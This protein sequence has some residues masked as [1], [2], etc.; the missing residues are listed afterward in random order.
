MSVRSCQEPVR[1]ARHDQVFGCGDDG[2]A[3]GGAVGE[4]RSVA[5]SDVESLRQDI[6]WGSLI[7]PAA[8]G[9]A[10]M[11]VDGYVQSDDLRALDRHYLLRP[12]DEDGNAAMHVLPIGQRSY[13]RSKLRLAAD[14]A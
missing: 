1:L 7:S 3:H 9:I 2:R 12:A 13:P 14:L 11:D 5:P 8:S 6:R 4:R 10:S